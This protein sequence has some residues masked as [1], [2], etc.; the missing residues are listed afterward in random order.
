M[1]SYSEHQLIREPRCDL[2]ARC[3]RCNSPLLA[4]FGLKGEGLCAACAEGKTIQWMPRR[5]P[6]IQRLVRMGP[7]ASLKSKL[8]RLAG[9]LSRAS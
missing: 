3:L 2:S 4:N 6:Y 1:L 5:D 9:A 8:R 7:P